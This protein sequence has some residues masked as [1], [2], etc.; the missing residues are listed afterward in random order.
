MS[1]LRRYSP[2]KPSR[3]TVI[4]PG[5]RQ[6]VL[7]RDAGCVGHRV[8]GMPG[9]CTFGLELDHVRASGALGAKS[10]STPDNLV[11]LCPTAHWLKTHEGRKW[12]PPLLAY[13][14]RVE[15]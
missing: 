13:L 7:L 1:T 14:A 6:H 4:P 15:S 10:R 2:L 11:A 8:V 9:P 12:R 3:G 5:V